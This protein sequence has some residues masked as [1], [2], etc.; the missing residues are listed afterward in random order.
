MSIFNSPFKRFTQFRGMPSPVVFPM[1]QHDPRQRREEMPAGDRGGWYNEGA[2]WDLEEITKSW[3]ARHWG[4]FQRYVVNKLHARY[5]LEP[6]FRKLKE[7]PKNF[8]AAGATPD[9]VRDCTE[10]A[11]TS[12]E[13][14]AVSARPCRLDKAMHSTAALPLPWVRLGV[15]PLPKNTTN[16]VPIKVLQPWGQEFDV[17]VRLGRSLICIWIL[18]L[19][20]YYI[21]SVTYLHIWRI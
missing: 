13:V 6:V 15:M 5:Q 9:L 10:V 1:R 11:L 19:W 12:G 2:R 16:A 14:P 7:K 20:Q 18:Y 21:L 8:I 4:D 17:A 3:E